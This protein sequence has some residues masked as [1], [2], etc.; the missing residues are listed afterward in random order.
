M[1]GHTPTVVTESTI[2]VKWCHVNDAGR[3]DQ[4]FIVLVFDPTEKPV[5]TPRD[6]ENDNRNGTGEKFHMHSVI[7]M[8]TK[9]ATVM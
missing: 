5:Q 4:N 6:G 2:A 9:H 1:L 7:D 3:S 8:E